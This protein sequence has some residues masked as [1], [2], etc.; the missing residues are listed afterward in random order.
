MLMRI[1][2]FLVLLSIGVLPS[3]DRGLNFPF[4]PP[5]YHGQAWADITF[6]PTEKKEIFTISEIF[7]SSSVEYYRFDTDPFTTTYAR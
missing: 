1:L 2:I 3:P 6:T 4:T 5:Y 7:A